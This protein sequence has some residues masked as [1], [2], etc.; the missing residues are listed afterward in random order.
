M[1]YPSILIGIGVVLLGG[2]FFTKGQSAQVYCQTNGE[3]GNKKPIQSHRSYCLKPTSQQSNYTPK[4]PVTY[5]FTIID[6]R[7]NILKEFDTVHEKIMHVIIVRKDLAEFQHIH[8]DFNSQTGEF[9]LSALT[10]P[11]DGNYRLFADF[12]PTSSQIRPDNMKLPVTLS[13]DISVGNTAHYIPQALGSSEN[14]KTVDGYSVTLTTSPAPIKNN[15]ETHLAFMIEKD[16]KPVTNLEPYLGALGHSVILSEGNLDFIHAHAMNEATA[17]QN[18]TITF[19]TTFP[20]AGKY[21]AFTQFQH[22][23]KVVTTDFVI[24]VTEGET[25]TD[26]PTLDHENMG[27]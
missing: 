5:S 19:V 23:G 27:H 3:L 7:G 4:Q 21:K 20:K 13:S 26:A 10:F 22:E 16:G 11:S 18:G 14:K 17:T 12:T 1:K 25:A 15:E 6:D 9:T 24:E 2:W 8:P